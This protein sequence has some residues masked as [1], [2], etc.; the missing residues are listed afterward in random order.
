MTIVRLTTQTTIAPLAPTIAVG[1]T[2]FII[3]VSIELVALDLAAM[4][5]EMLLSH[6]L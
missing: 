2:F 4:E 1:L 3:M 6:Q 5:K